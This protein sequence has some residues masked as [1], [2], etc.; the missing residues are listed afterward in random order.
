MQ[1]MQNGNLRISNAIKNQVIAENAA[2]DAVM[3]IARNQRKG[4][5]R[6]R[7][8][9]GCQTA[10]NRDP[11]SASKK[12]SDSNSVQPV[13]VFMMR[14]QATVREASPALRSHTFAVLPT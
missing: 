4:P 7:Q 10:R 1:D 2:A 3:L 13:Y 9:Q 6:F 14:V 12:G 11:R 8:R 5:R